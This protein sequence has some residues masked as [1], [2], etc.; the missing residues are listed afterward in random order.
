MTVRPIGVGLAAASMLLLPAPIAAQEAPHGALVIKDGTCS[1]YYPF[2]PAPGDDYFVAFF[3]TDDIQIVRTHG[4]TQTVRCR[5][6]AVEGF[7]PDKAITITDGVC[8]MGGMVGFGGYRVTATPNGKVI[9]T[10]QLNPGNPG[11]SFIE[12]P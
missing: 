7:V 10:C 4:D 3:N 9:A 1:W 12:A 5:A 11:I 6:D 8:F 2:A